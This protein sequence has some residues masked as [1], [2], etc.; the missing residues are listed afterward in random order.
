M[1]VEKKGMLKKKQV[2]EIISD[3]D[4][5]ASNLFGIGPLGRC[6]CNSVL[7]HRRCLARALCHCPGSRTFWH[8]LASHFKPFHSGNISKGISDQT[9][10]DS[11]VQLKFSC[12]Y[13]SGCLVTGNRSCR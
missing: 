3:F 2:T 10:I 12:T 6:R 9:D 1:A 4:A 11:L 7:T 5:A 13:C 8:D